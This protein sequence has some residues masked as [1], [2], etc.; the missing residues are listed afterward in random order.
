MF[1]GYQLEDKDVT[2]IQLAEDSLAFFHTKK[3]ANKLRHKVS[4]KKV[5]SFVDSGRFIEL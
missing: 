2:T 3:I 4:W 1:Y 5:E